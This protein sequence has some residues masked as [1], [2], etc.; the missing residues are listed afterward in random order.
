M[1]KNTPPNVSKL[2][3]FEIIPRFKHCEQKFDNF[4]S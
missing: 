3:N 2:Y 4:Y 1:I